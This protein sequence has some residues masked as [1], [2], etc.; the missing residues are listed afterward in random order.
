MSLSRHERSWLRQASQA[1]ARSDPRLTGMFA[2]FG[3]LTAQEPLPGHEQLPRL[4]HLGGRAEPPGPPRQGRPPH[5]ISS[6]LARPARA[7]AV[8]IAP[9]AAARGPT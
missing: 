6:A 8:F 2:I 1:L 9:A 3:R 4:A 5:R 7:A